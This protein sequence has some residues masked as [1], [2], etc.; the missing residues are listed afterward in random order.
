M[1]MEA[2][3]SGGDMMTEGIMEEPKAGLPIVPI[4][5][6]AAIVIILIVVT[7]MRKKR[8]ARKLLAEE[9]ELLDEL[10]GPSE[11]EQQ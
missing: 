10:D 8:K 7:I 9:E 5:V 3:E 2:M 1:V 6:A 11:D 4:A